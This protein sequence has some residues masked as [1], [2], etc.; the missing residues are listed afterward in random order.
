[1]SDF[2]APT[3]V[4]A[5]TLV[6]AADVNNLS[7]ATG[8][9]FAALPTNTELKTG[10]TVF[11]TDTGAA[12]AY[13][14]TLP[15]APSSYASGLS[16]RFIPLAT[17]TGASTINVNSLGV[18]SIRDPV[19]AALAAGLITVGVPCELCYSATTGYFHL[20]GALSPQG[21]AGPPGGLT[22]VDVSGGST[23]LT[24]TGG[25]I[26]SSGTITLGGTL[27][28]AYGGSGVANNAAATTTRVGAYA[29]TQTLSGISSVTY[30]ESGT[31]ATLTGTETLTNKTITGPIISG[32]TNAG[33]TFTTATLT[34][35]DINGGTA[36]ALTS[37]SLRNAGT[38][39]YD[40]T[41]AYNGTL[42]A[43][44]TLTW[45]LNDAARSVS[46]TGNLVLGG[47]FT[48]SGAYATTFTMTGTT[49]L[50]LP[51][52]GTV[53]TVI[54]DHAITVTTGNGHGSTNTCIRRF[55]TTESSVGTAIT[56]ADSAGNGGAFT[57]AAG[58]D[59]LYEVYAADSKTT[60]TSRYVG[61]SVNSNQLTTEILLITASHRKAI[62]A[63]T[64]AN[65]VTAVTR[66]LKLAAGDVVR[67]HTDGTNNATDPAETVFSIR[68]IA[69]A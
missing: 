9:A 34:A 41:F 65:V 22:S 68:K 20:I 4:A 35:P 52:S 66:V 58:N 49:T 32:G 29:L 61:I 16:V 37:L 12:D 8:T 48:T 28:A 53:A 64:V 14:V 13:L 60:S 23:G 39:A 45:N 31:L 42:T 11:G 40:A 67:L 51:E 6:R 27:G 62:A 26:T 38:G 10:K 17:N 2:T 54:G 1:M 5:A 56:Y 15:Y 55:T 18:K 24:A 19:G 57:I 69:A 25:P 59:G 7:D 46:L 3:A 43:G 63:Q 50:T 47:N 30:P 44:R 21:P 36:D 33:A